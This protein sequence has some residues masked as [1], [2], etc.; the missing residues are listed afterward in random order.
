[1]IMTS[2]SQCI[3]ASC[4]DET[5]RLIDMNAGDILNNY[6]GHSGAKEYRIEC[7]VVKGDGYIITGSKNGEAMIY[8]FLEATEMETL[9]IGG[10]SVICTLSKHPTQDQMLFANGR[11]IQCWS[12]N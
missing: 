12:F 2:D 3:L 8:N 5:I 11:E 4:Q 7:A 9:K 10:T 1:M 6:Q